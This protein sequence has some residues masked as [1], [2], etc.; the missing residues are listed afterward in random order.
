MGYYLLTP[1]TDQFKLNAL[2]PSKLFKSVK[3]VEFGK[4]CSLCRKFLMQ[5]TVNG[6][7]YHLKT[8][9]CNEIISML[10]CNRHL[11]RVSK[12]LKHTPWTNEFFAAVTHC[13]DM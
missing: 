6:H 12:S 7:K 10:I 5:V 3:F 1:L 13:G 9:K 4:G 11:S 8:D 2:P